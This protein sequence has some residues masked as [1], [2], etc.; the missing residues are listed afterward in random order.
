M[1]VAKSSAGV[2]WVVGIV[3][4]EGGGDMAWNEAVALLL[5]ASGW[6]TVADLIRSSLRDEDVPSGLRLSGASCVDLQNRAVDRMPDRADAS[7]TNSRH[8]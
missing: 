7:T 4:V 8:R 3:D 2:C 6:I 5:I 1:P